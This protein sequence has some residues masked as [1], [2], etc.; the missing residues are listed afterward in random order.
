MYH[1][2]VWY[3]LQ[4]YALLL[5][6]LGLG[7]LLLWRKRREMRKR[8]LVITAA[9]ALL[10]LFSLRIVSYFVLGSL[11]WHSPPLRSRPDDAQGIVVLSS[12]VYR[13][14]R[15]RIRPELDEDGLKRCML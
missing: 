9:W 11:E 8:L 2:L 4:P 15:I 12:Y 7:L 3:L 13:P 10:C 6:A 5:L 14:D 1:L